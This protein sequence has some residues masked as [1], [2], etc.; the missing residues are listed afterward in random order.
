MLLSHSFGL[1]GPFRACTIPGWGL[2]LPGNE[3]FA[4]VLRAVSGLKGLLSQL[5]A[6]RS[7]EQSR[8]VACPGY[9]VKSRWA[10]GIWQL[11][12]E[13]LTEG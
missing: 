10:S 9:Q 4:H 2:N 6:Q 12:S 3:L 13:M 1:L 11:N 8:D 7:G 5:L